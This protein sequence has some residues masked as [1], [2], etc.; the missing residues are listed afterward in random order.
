M[1]RFALPRCKLWC[2]LSSLALG[3]RAVLAPRPVD[4]QGREDR[5]GLAHVRHLRV[6]VDAY[7]QRDVA[8]PNGGLGHPRRRAAGAHH[9]PERGPQRVYVQGAVRPSRFGM[10][11]FLKSR[12]RIL[13]SCGETKHTRPASNLGPGSDH[14]PSY[15]PR[16]PPTKTCTG[17]D[18]CGPW[19]P[20]VRESRGRSLPHYTAHVRAGTSARD[21]DE[22]GRT[23]RG[24]GR[25]TPGRSEH[26]RPHKSGVKMP[27]LS[28][29][30]FTVRSAP[31]C[32]SRRRAGKIRGPQ[33]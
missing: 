18:R 12:L 20:R 21:R 27:G 3:A 22:V 29:R 5:R 26:P 13:V 9:R 6:G 31:P 19:R 10:P 2:K 8:R 14:R 15:K 33:S 28:R 7:R 4:R 1:P 24:L 11:A 23:Q 30:D 32:G 17:G 16:T 25:T